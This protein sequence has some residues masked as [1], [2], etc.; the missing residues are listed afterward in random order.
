M[1]FSTTPARRAARVGQRAPERADHAGGHRPR[2]AVRVA[3]RDHELADLEVVGVAELG[4]HEVAVLD[5]QHRQVGER[6]GAD[7]RE[8]VSRPSTNDAR[9][10]APPS[11]TCAEVTR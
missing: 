3:D 5:A 2:E 8:A 6:V 11:T 4:G 9:P 1:T 10:C 7:H